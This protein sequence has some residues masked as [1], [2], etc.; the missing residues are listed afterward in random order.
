MS[1]FLSLGSYFAIQDFLSGWFHGAPF[2]QIHRENCVAFVAYAFYKRNYGD[3]PARVG[4]AA[5][6]FACTSFACALT[7]SFTH[8]HSL[9]HS[10]TRSLARSLVYCFSPK[11]LRKSSCALFSCQCLTLLLFVL[12]SIISPALLAVTTAFSTQGT[13]LKAT[14]EHNHAAQG[15]PG[16]SVLWC[17]LLSCWLCEFTH[18]M[19]RTR[20]NPAH[21]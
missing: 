19:I 4:R 3:L 21:R 9:T 14:S 17:V 2:D 8:S 15:P 13:F 16:S 18:V 20:S 7:H 5:V 6:L 1:R 11:H 12:C 10:L